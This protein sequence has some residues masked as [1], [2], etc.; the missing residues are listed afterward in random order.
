MKKQVLADSGL[1]LGSRVLHPKFGEGVL[2]SFEGQGASTR[3][4]VNFT[5]EGSK[6]LV[7]QYARLEVL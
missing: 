2:I 1:H 7:L 5:T 3:V 6:W 4:Q